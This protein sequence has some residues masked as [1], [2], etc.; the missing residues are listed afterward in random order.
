MRKSHV[1]RGFQLTI[2]YDF[3]LKHF[4]PKKKYC[5]LCCEDHKKIVMFKP[6]QNPVGGTFSKGWADFDLENNIE[7]DDI[8]LFELVDPVQKQEKQEIILKVCSFRAVEEMVPLTCLRAPRSDSSARKTLRGGASGQ[9][10]GRS[11]SSL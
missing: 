8:C 7:E 11:K 9:G 2:P 6:R 1:Y 5:T 4:P 3:A 10:R